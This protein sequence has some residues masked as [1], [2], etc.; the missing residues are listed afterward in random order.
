M[1]TEELKSI[2]ELR[3]EMGLQGADLSSF[4]RDERADAR[5]RR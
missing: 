4:V 1:D 3:K 2:V 5:E